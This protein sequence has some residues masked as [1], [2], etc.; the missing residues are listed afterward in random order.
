MARAKTRK[1]RLRQVA[2]WLRREFPTPYSVRLRIEALG[3]PG[4]QSG[5]WGETYRSRS[6]RSLTLR[7]DSRIKWQEA[8]DVLLHE[9]A[10]A[11]T[12]RQEWVENR[13]PL[14]D[15]EWALQFGKIYRAFHDEGGD[16]RSRG[17]PS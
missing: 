6:G 10:H 12:W 14:H 2:N 5:N 17:Y 1:G 13:R 15:D 11:V 9:W 16:V 8:I 3:P 4:K 7:I